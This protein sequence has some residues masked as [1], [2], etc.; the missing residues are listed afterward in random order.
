MKGLCLTGYFCFSALMLCAQN[1][2]AV[3]TGF[4]NSAPV[5]LVKWYKPNLVTERGCTVYRQEEGSERW[6]KVTANAVQY[7]GYK[8]SEEDKNA[9]RDL[10]AY[11]QLA[12]HPANLKGI[13]L[14]AILVKSFSSEPLCRYLGNIFYDQN[15]VSGKKYRY[16]VQYQHKGSLTE[17]SASRWI[18]AGSEQKEAA[19][20]QF[21]VEQKKKVARLSWRPEP[22]RYY[23]THVYRKVGDTGVFR[24]LTKDP[25]ILSQHLDSSG[26]NK[27]PAV[28][29]EDQGLPSKTEIY[30]HLEGLDFFADATEK[31]EVVKIFV[32]DLE[33]PAPVDSLRLKSN[34]K[35]IKVTWRK[36][37]AEE[38]LGGFNIYRTTRNDTDFS[39]VNYVPLASHVRQYT[40]TAPAVGSYMYKVVAVDHDGNE[41][42]AE[43][44]FAEAYDNEPPAKPEQLVVSGDT[45]RVIISW[46]EGKEKDLQGYLIYRTINGDQSNTYVKLTPQPV[47]CCRY[48]DSLHASVKNKIMY[49]LVAVDVNLNRS[50]YSEPA[51]ARMP[52]VVPPSRPFLRALQFG[53]DKQI[54]AEWLSNPE[55]DLVQYDLFS[56]EI[57]DT[58][59]FSRV[60]INPIPRDIRKYTDRTERLPGIYVFHLTAT[61]STGNVSAASNTLIIKCKPSKET[62]E[63][64][65]LHV[66]YHRRQKEVQLK[67]EHNLSDV[68]GYIVYRCEGTQSAFEP[69]GGFTSGNKLTDKEIKSQNKYRYQVRAYHRSGDVI[70]SEAVNVLIN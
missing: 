41:S 32:P 60:N 26:N 52:D 20:E 35:E 46:K 48:Y 56:K 55:N 7:R 50:E 30:Y 6:Q 22:D 1:H 25:V 4:T 43:A 54:I 12:A 31:S 36:S 15:V 49:K 19:P 13:G 67:W 33:A 51:G 14:I 39:K 62:T 16:K 11:V 57:N 9:D 10:S 58:M 68:R 44:K 45:G 37:R 70:R 21:Q 63:P 69:L 24:R 5:V 29:Y 23:A 53:A 2:V 40:D 61:D 42:A 17:L 28:L 38:D 65:V 3:K 47:T 59:G 18:V 64:P 34:G 8:I 66:K 27:Y